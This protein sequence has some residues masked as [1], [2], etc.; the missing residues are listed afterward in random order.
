MFIYDYINMASSKTVIFVWTQH[1]C[2]IRVSNKENFFG[3]GD[4]IRGM[5]ATYEIC[6]KLEF[7][8]YIDIQHHPL[9]QCLENPDHRYQ[10]FVKQQKDEVWFVPRERDLEKFLKTTNHPQNII[11]MMTNNYYENIHPI[12][13]TELCYLFTQHQK[14]EFETYY[15]ETLKSLQ[16]DPSYEILH[17]RLGD[18]H[19]VRNEECPVTFESL[20]PLF[21]K[22]HKPN[23]L[24]ISDNKIW[25]EYLKTQ[26]TDITIFAVSQIGHFGY[27]NDYESIRDTLVEFLLVLNSSRIYTY[28]VY[29]WRSGFVSIPSALQNINIETM[30]P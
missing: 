1:C 8:F 15:K 11:C 29:P 6:R 12:I 10:S 16:L 24:V 3:I 28:S 14:P 9:S 30:T 4:M 27:H 2:N 26:H 17:F 23:Q 25:K 19:M 22:Y 7:D 21:E 20:K 18:F 5:I 13:Q